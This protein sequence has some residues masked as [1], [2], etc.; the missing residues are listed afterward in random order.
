MASKPWRSINSRRM[1]A[2]FLSL[3]KRKM[4]VGELLLRL[5]EAKGP[6]AGIYVSGLSNE[7]LPYASAFWSMKC[8]L[9]EL[10]ILNAWF[11]RACIQQPF[12]RARCLRPICQLQGL[13]NCHFS[14]QELNSRV[15]QP[16]S[17]WRL[18]VDQ[19]AYCYPIGGQRCT[20]R[21]RWPLRLEVRLPLAGYCPQA[22]TGLEY[23]RS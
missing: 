16:L 7:R 21:S 2:H 10:A 13:P 8:C 14:I 17:A 5:S 3:K 1:I 23:C 20:N 4:D 22:K 12:R 9:W 19:Q 11:S 18:T 6:L 15:Y